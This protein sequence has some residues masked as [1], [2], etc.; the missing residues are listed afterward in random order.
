MI[1]RKVSLDAIPADQLVGRFAAITAAQDDALLGHELT[2]FNRLF[3]RMMEVSEEL[4]R[5]PGDQ[6]R[7]LMALYSH[8]NMQ[9][10]LQ[11]A[12]LTLAVAP[13]E[14]RRK[15]EAIAS[16]RWLPQSGDAGMCLIN[17]D[18]GIFKPT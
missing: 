16:S 1:F 18:R 2:K 5:R 6:R 7:A 9:V 13:D 4:K 11:A 8:P 3:D 12:K 15:I 17:L 10:Q 14:A